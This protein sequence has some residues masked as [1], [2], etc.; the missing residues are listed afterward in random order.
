MSQKSPD[1][2]IARWRKFGKDRL[3]VALA[4]GT[5]VGYWDLV[6]DEPH[7]ESASL[8]A[9]LARA[10]EAWLHRGEHTDP[11]GQ[12]TEQWTEQDPGGPSIAR[13]G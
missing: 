6:T 5:K 2:A 9:L 8:A 10:H 4:D 7:P 1:L 3:Y 12:P 13:A 11:T